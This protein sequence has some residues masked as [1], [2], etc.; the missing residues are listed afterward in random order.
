[1]LGTQAP[2]STVQDRQCR[3]DVVSRGPLPRAIRPALTGSEKEESRNNSATISPATTPY[4]TNSLIVTLAVIWCC[5]TPHGQRQGFRP[6]HRQ[7]DEQHQAGG[8]EAR[9]FAA[10]V[11]ATRHRP[12]RGNV[13]AMARACSR[14]HSSTSRSRTSTLDR[15]SEG[16]R[17][18]EVFIAQARKNLLPV[19]DRTVSSR[20]ARSFPGIMRSRRTATPS[21][22]PYM[23]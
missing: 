10:V 4:R 7:A 20:T 18:A 17:A 21:A 6:D 12:L 2:T 22:T 3:G 8:I 13:G 14:T 15:R 19:R 23:I 16:R 1:M 5:S 9:T 11:R